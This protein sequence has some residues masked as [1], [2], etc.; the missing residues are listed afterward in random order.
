M[1]IVICTHCHQIHHFICHSGKI[2]KTLLI[3]IFS[4]NFFIGTMV[5]EG[6][7]FFRALFCRGSFL[8][9]NI[10]QVRIGF[11][12]SLT[13]NNK[14]LINPFSTAKYSQSPLSFFIYLFLL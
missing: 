14:H 4:C 6:P 7:L 9:L 10:C 11:S 3:G 13:P 2:L 12:S 8:I 1:S 5:R